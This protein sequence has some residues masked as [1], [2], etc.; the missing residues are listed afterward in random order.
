MSK[1]E[2]GTPSGIDPAN[3]T[4]PTTDASPSSEAQVALQDLRQAVEGGIFPEQVAEEVFNAIRADKFYILT[5]RDLYNP[6]VQKR[7]EDIL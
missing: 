1:P 6:A 2:S 4:T 3:C 7:M 5:Q